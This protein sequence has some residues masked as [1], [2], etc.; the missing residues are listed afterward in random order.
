MELTDTAKRFVLH[1][2]EMGSRWGINRTMAQIHGL[3]FM[4]ARPL[5][6]EDIAET[7][8]VARSNVSNCLRELQTW[9]VVRLSHVMGDRRDHF[10]TFGDVWELFRV[11]MQG[12]KQRAIDPTIELLRE[13]IAAPAFKNE[14]EALQQR[15][16]D[17]LQFFEVLT[18]WSGEMLSLPP[19]ML[20][21]IL[22]MGADVQQFMPGEAVKDK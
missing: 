15:V 11:I 10:E 16:S 6:A 8:L 21:P 20:I 5:H 17:T 12:R 1:W 3:L 14:H 9:N 19:E 22:T 18:T 4:T 2:G 13:L 7:L